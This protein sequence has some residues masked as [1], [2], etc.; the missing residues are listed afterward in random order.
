MQQLHHLGDLDSM[1]SPTCQTVFSKDNIQIKVTQAPTGWGEKGLLA[2][3]SNGGS[4]KGQM[5]VSYCP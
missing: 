5:S 1:S 4:R 2:Q 3:G